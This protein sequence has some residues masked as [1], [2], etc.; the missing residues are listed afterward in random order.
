MNIPILELDQ[1]LKAVNG[2]DEI[3]LFEV[4]FFER[5][6]ASNDTVRRSFIILACLLFVLLGA[7]GYRVSGSPASSLFPPLPPSSN[8]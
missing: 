6:K 5:G 4:L 8:I 3:N 1:L 2:S 7:A